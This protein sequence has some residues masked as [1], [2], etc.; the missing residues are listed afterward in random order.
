MVVVY[1]NVT[2][3]WSASGS[4][5]HP[6]QRALAHLTQQNAACLIFY[7]ENNFT[8]VRFLSMGWLI[9]LSRFSVLSV[10]FDFGNCLFDSRLFGLNINK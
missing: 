3:Y 5:C 8:L 7:P 2:I 6:H 4:F 9:G 10:R 1:T